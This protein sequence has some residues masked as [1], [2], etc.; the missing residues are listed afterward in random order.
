MSVLLQCWAFVNTN[1]VSEWVFIAL[2]VGMMYM[3]MYMYAHSMKYLTSAMLSYFGQ[4][5]A[6]PLVVVGA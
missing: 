2:L 6:T 3:Y 4:V 5:G 1:W